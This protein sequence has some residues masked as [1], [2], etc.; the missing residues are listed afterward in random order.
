MN[1]LEFEKRSYDAWLASA[2]VPY[3]ILIPLLHR[4]NGSGQVH[5]SWEKSDNPFSKTDH[6]AVYRYPQNQKWYGLIMNIKE[7]LLTK[8]TKE[9]DSPNVE[10]MNLKIV[11]NSFDYFY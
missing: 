10:I 7:S 4:M 2:E 8:G 1:Q 6:I 5:E 9:E 3:E 11:Q